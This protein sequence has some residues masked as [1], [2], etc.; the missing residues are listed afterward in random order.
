MIAA[1]RRQPLRVR[2]VSL[3]GVLLTLALLS[4]GSLALALLRSSLVAEVDAQLTGAAQSLVDS[5]LP[6]SDSDS[7][8]WVPSDYAVLIATIDGS[9]T[10]DFTTAQRPSVGSLALADVQRRGPDPFT[11]GSISGSTRWRAITAPISTST[12]QIVGTVAVALPLDS[13]DATMRRMLAALISVSVGVLGVTAVATY[14]V[15]RSSLAPLRRIEAT[16][17]RIAAGDLSQRVEPAPVSTEVGSLAESLNTML[18]EMESAFEVRRLSEERMQA[19]VGDASHELRTPLASVAGYAELYRLGGIPE[20]ELPR[21]MARIEDSAARMSVLVTELLALARLDQ[22]APVTL[23]R[24][25]L[26]ERLAAAASDLRA[27]D[28]Q[29]EVRVVCELGLAVVADDGLLSQILTNLVGNAAAYTPAGSPVEVVA[30]AGPDGV[31]IEVRDHGPGI[32][33]AER[34]RVFERFARLDAGRAR[35]TG[36]SGLGLAIARSAA[37]AMGGDL[38]CVPTDP[39]PGATM[40]LR[41]PAADR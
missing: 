21:V 22:G 27:L 4:V 25:D 34:E 20:E 41:L 29:R 7:A 12:G 23:A 36:G 38:T 37:R 13:V 19:F 40:R 1:W 17:A 6:R 32:P 35:D 33:A 11:V 28:P 26:A 24:V 9:I 31:T 15:V 8:S 5:T 14:A 39:G 16:A 3:F 30:Q 18:G 2:L 10:L